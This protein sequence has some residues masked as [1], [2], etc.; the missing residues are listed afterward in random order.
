MFA[1]KI[2]VYLLQNCKG[3]PGRELFLSAN[4]IDEYKQAI[5]KV[6]AKESSTV[7]SWEAGVREYYDANR[8]ELLMRY[9]ENWIE[10]DYP[11]TLTISTALNGAPQPRVSRNSPRSILDS[12]LRA[13]QLHRFLECV[14]FID[15]AA[16]YVLAPNIPNLNTMP[17][18]AETVQPHVTPNPSSSQ[19]LGKQLVKDYLTTVLCTNLDPA[20]PVSPVV[21]WIK[22]AKT[23]F[24]VVKSELTA[25]CSRAARLNNTLRYIDHAWDIQQ[26]SNAPAI[27]VLETAYA[28]LP[29][30][31]IARS[32]VMAEMPEGD[33]E[34]MMVTAARDT[35]LSALWE[36]RALM[37]WCSEAS[38]NWWASLDPDRRDVARRQHLKREYVVSSPWLLLLPKPNGVFR[39]QYRALASPQDFSAM[40]KANAAQDPSLIKAQFKGL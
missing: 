31:P 16:A 6:T 10:N 25:L 39:Q 35:Y 15:P 32:F 21:S 37:E 13:T 30:E 4:T 3:G 1:P 27:D 34:D 5:A 38:R 33:D 36:A 29:I 22:L 9:W 28:Y 26:T 24:A 12:C 18:C 20:Y 7:N 11:E 17:R 19:Q 2:V 40:F 14:R 23:S 8:A